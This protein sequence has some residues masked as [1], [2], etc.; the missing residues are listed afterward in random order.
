MLLTKMQTT[1][2]PAVAREDAVEPIQF[3]LQYWSSESSQI[4]DLS[5]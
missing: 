3:L 1:R 5:L 2:S 4:N